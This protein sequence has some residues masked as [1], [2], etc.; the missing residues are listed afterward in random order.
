[1][2]REIAE[3][4]NAAYAISV[5]ASVTLGPRFGPPIE[6][7]ARKIRKNRI[8][9]GGID[10]AAHSDSHRIT[11]LLVAAAMKEH[12]CHPETTNV[13]AANDVYIL[14]ERER[15]RTDAPIARIRSAARSAET[16]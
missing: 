9:I 4:T 2:G 6:G 15:S 11:G 10:A 7:W 12:R 14:S 5:H 13:I 8:A 1:M 16:A 3:V